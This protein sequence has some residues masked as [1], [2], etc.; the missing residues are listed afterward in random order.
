MPVPQVAIEESEQSEG[1]RMRPH[2]L[3]AFLVTGALVVACALPGGT[4]D[5]VARQEAAI[6]VWVV[7]A[8]GFALGAIPLARPRSLV[9]LSMAALAALGGWMLLSLGWTESDERTLAEACRVAGYLGLLLLVLNVLD[10]QT[11]RAAAAGLSAG[12]LLVAALSTASWLAPDA[13]PADRV[14]EFSNLR[15]NYPFGYWNAVGAWGSMAVTAALAWSVNAPHPAL[16]AAYLAAVP[17]AGLSIYL[18]Y[19]RAALAGIAAGVLVVLWLSPRRVQA[20]AHLLAAAGATAA[21]IVAVRSEPAVAHGVEG[22]GAGVVL[23]VLLVGGAVCAAVAVGTWTAGADRRWRLPRRTGRA[24]AIAAAA[25]VVVAAALAGPGLASRAWDSFSDEGDQATFAGDPAE[26]F[27]NLHGPRYSVWSETL[28]IFRANPTGGTGAGTFEFPWS[29]SGRSPHFV[30]DAHS[31]YLEPLAETGWP[32]ALLTLL[33]LGALLVASVYA[34]RRSRR[35]TTKGA[36][37]SM[38]AVLAVFLVHAGVDWMWESTAVAVVGLGA[39]AIACVRLTDTDEPPGLAP[40]GRALATIGSLAVCVLL[41]PG[42]VSTS[43]VRESREAARAGDLDGAVRQAEGAVDSAPWSATAH[44]QRGAVA[45][46]RGDLVTARR[47]V[48]RAAELEPTNWRPA[49]VLARVELKLGRPRA[50]RRSLARARR[51][52]PGAL[53]FADPPPG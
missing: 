31:I 9:W 45:E 46:A 30:R 2:A 39:G 33:F 18:S 47:E 17:V 38:T 36:A 37:V 35:A 29:R 24:A 52:R 28:E 11:W 1:I 22:G 20:A 12:A 16:R 10:R 41:L 3:A 6:A 53:V 5:I 48:R 51:L 50:A 32:G 42:V 19:S 25:C 13:F 49:F 27:G 21:A 7:L 34:V 14:R 40:A 43:L 44:M 4:Y 15:L 26:R 23:L 8:V